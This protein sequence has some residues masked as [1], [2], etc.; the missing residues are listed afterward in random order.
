VWGE[1]TR[2]MKAVE[3]VPVLLA[4][5]EQPVVAKPACGCGRAY[6]CV[7]K[8]WA[9]E[10]GKACKKVGLMWLKKAYGTAGNAIYCGYDNA[11]GKAL[12]KANAIC[13]ALR[14]AGVSAYTDAV[15]D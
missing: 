2:K 3:L 10:V 1:E 8:A 14:A 4:A 11:D 12:A 5:L 6:V 15:A 7:G 13:E 9:T